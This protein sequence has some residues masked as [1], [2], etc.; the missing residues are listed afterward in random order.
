M[1]ATAPLRLAVL[2]QADDQ[3]FSDELPKWKKAAANHRLDGI[4]TNYGDF[5]EVVLFDR[6]KLA[7]IDTK[8]LT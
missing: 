4:K 5:F 8:S 6:A 2:D 3:V 1:S 7:H